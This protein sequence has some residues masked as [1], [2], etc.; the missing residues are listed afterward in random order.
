MARI[1]YFEQIKAFFSWQFN[2]Q[3]RGV[4]PHHISLYM[5]LLNQNNRNNWVEWFKCPYDLAMAGSAI[6]SK[7]TYY[8]TLNDLKNWKLIDFKKG[9]NE[10]K[11]PLIKV[12]VQKCTSTNTSGVPQGE[13]LS[14]PLPT[15]LPTHIYRLITLNLK[16]I[17]LY[18]EDVVDFLKSKVSEDDKLGFYKIRGKILESFSFIEQL[19]RV[20]KLPVEQV[21]ARVEEYFKEREECLDVKRNEMDYRNHLLNT[22]KKNIN[23]NSGIKK[24]PFELAKELDYDE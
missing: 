6:G 10:F 9:V 1:N 24:S 13:P 21:Q 7:K 5:F 4:K 15:P 2:N 3:D 17:I 18:I 19:S 20:S 8:R 12:E 22:F 23:G 14:I 11:A 16:P